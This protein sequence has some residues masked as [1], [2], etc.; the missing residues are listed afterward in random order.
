MTQYLLCLTI[1][2]K[3]KNTQIRSFTK[4]LSVGDEM[5][6]VDGTDGQARRS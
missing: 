1:T 5:F 4:I 3:P 6:H 2:N